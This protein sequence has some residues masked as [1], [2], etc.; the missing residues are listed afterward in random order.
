MKQF[1]NYRNIRRR[2]L[3]YGLPLLPFAL[4]MMAVVASLIMIIFSFSLAA[5]IFSV[6]FNLV[7][8]ISLLKVS[9]NP[10]LLNFKRVFPCAISNKPISGLSYED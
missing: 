10:E 4:Q 1:Q 9:S 7:L 8:Y 3:I 2:A 5:I 6:V